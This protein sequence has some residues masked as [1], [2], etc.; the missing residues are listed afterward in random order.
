MNRQSVSSGFFFHW[1]A[2][3]LFGSFLLPDSLRNLKVPSGL[4][5]VMKADNVLPKNE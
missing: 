1:Q 5:K 4:P 2:I 3:C